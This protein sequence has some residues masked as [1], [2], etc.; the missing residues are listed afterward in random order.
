MEV[1]EKDYSVYQV[2]NFLAD[3]QF[4]RHVK[5]PDA[6]SWARRNQVA[7]NWPLH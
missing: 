6:A 7:A 1:F 2:I 5:Y 4:I 3:E